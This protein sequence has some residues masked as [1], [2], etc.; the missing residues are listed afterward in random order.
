MPQGLAEGQVEVLEGLVEFFPPADGEVVG[1]QAPHLFPQFPETLEYVLEPGIH[2]LSRA[3]P[4]QKQQAAHRQPQEVLV[5][6]LILGPQGG[7][8]VKELDKVGHRVTARDQMI[9][10]LGSPW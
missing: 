9:F 1:G 8:V 2:L 10:R 7:R 3:R 6:A 4:D 5:Q